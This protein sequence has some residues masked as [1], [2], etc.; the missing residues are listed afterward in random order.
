MVVSKRFQTG[1]P[2][3]PKLLTTLLIA[4]L[5]VSCLAFVVPQAQAVYIY[6]VSGP[7]YDDGTIPNENVT[8]TA[9]FMNNTIYTFQLQGN[10]THVDNV[11]LTSTSQISKMVWNASSANNYTRVNDIFFGLYGTRI[12]IPNPATYS[13][14]YSFTVT[15]FYGMSNPY[16][17]TSVSSDGINYYVVESKLIESNPI[18]FVLQ[19]YTSYRLTFRCTQGTYTQTFSAEEVFTI[20][21]LVM[22][23]AFLSTNTTYIEANATRPTSTSIL[24]QY[25][26]PSASTTWMYY[27][28]THKVGTTTYTDY[29]YN[30]TG[31]SQSD[32]WS[33]ANATVDY[34]VNMQA[35]VGTETYTWTIPVSAST[36]GTNPF[37][38]LITPLGTWPS[39]FN[40]DELPW[41]IIVIC[42]AAIFS[43]WSVTAGAFL[44]WIIAGVFMALGWITVIPVPVYG[45]A[46]VVCFLV[47]Y[48][49]S[50][51]TEREL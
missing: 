1:G 26:D 50:K 49:E 16:L 10:G 28:V 17:Q 19:Q 41:I 12:Y 8:V 31:S 14:V 38:G 18:T 39:G 29:T 36:I 3:I 11:N 48:A 32:L 9:Y 5:C 46:G 40:A 42:V 22:H 35:L 51:K 47:G 13:F 4:V 33:S 30:N 20:D 15:D 23:G 25:L 44:S 43:F 2:N 6:P 24:T 7:Y 27:T 34:T 21:L 37:T 45:L